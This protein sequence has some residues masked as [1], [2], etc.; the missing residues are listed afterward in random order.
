MSLDSFT[1]G[2]A[3]LTSADRDML[4]ALCMMAE[5]VLDADGAAGSAGLACAYY[6]RLGAAPRACNR[7]AL[8]HARITDSPI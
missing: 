5:D 4:S 3:R 2:I 1:T 6:A 8:R 7:G